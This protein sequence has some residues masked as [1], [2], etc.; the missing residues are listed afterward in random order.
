MKTLFF[1]GT[2]LSM[3]EP[4]PVESLLV[5]EGRIVALGD[6]DQVAPLA[7]GAA[8]VNLEGRTL[9]PAFVDGHS[10]ITALAQTLGLC[11]LDR[12]GSLQEVGRRLKDFRESLE[13]PRRGVGRLGLGTTKTS[14]KRDAIPRQQSWTPSFRIARPWWPTPPGIWVRLTP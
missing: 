11:Q 14:W 7:Q 9:L 2:I 13:N 5:E 1:G 4:K 3:E 12:C 10:H 6:L 8:R